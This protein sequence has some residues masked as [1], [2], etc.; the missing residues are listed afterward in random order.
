MNVMSI[1]H[2]S[3]KQNELPWGVVGTSIE[4]L[5]SCQREFFGVVFVAISCT[6]KVAGESGSALE[7]RVGGAVVRPRWRL[8][9][10][11]LAGAISERIA[12]R[13]ALRRRGHESGSWV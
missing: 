8:L 5:A 7:R 9:E 10:V 3:W 13:L 4:A 12:I 1:L 2:A 11:G 6:T